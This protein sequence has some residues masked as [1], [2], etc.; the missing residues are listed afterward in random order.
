MLKKTVTYTDYNG[1][2][3]TEDFYFNLNKAE[4]VE[5]EMSE[6]GGMSEQI[7][8]MIKTDD[9]P[10]IIRIFKKLLLSAYGEKSPDGRRFIKND[11]IRDSF[12]QSEAYSVLFMELTSST[13]T[14]ASF[15]NS[16]IPKDLEES[17]RKADN[18]IGLVK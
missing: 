8:R 3:R 9:Y 18:S 7:Q 5:M 16:V 17:V 6:S 11:E 4:L 15:I 10:T 12:E 13:D 2:E 1:V 14:L